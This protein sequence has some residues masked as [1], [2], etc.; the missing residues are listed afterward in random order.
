[1]N[2]RS[3]SIQLVVVMG[4]FMASCDSAHYDPQPLDLVNGNEDLQQ[5]Y[6]L[7]S[8]K[9]P[10][11]ILGKVI[12]K[13]TQEPIAKATVTAKLDNSTT[14]Y[15]TLS[16]TDGTFT[17]Y[18]EGQ[19]PYVI[20]S[21]KDGFDKSWY[22]ISQGD[23]TIFLSQEFD[24]VQ[25]SQTIHDPTPLFKVNYLSEETTGL[26]YATDLAFNGTNL[27]SNYNYG[28]NLQKYNASGTYLSDLYFPY[29]VDIFGCQGSTYYWISSGSEQLSQISASTGNE[30]DYI[31]LNLP[32]VYITDVE[33]YSNNL[34]ALNYYG[35]VIKV[36]TDGDVKGS[37]Y[38]SDVVDVSQML[39]VAQA[40]NFIFVLLKNTDGWYM[41]YKI[42][43]ANLN[44]VAKG[45]LPSSLNSRLLTGL[46][47]D[48]TH[49]WTIGE[50]ETLIKLGIE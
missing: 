2:V 32:S 44:I 15:S 30:S 7:K 22:F 12:N 49:F 23:S 19:L 26:S 20:Y 14:K 16:R 47:F 35:T 5:E 48:N 10:I 1:M 29:T 36:S 45:I 18:A 39:G 46:A 17:L 33:Y 6:N 11:R 25:I 9:N 31:D 38:F 40:N 27:L 24:G 21:E 4:L 37:V 13:K 8:M 50:S 3:I 28:Y 42:D 41:L 43:P 34:W